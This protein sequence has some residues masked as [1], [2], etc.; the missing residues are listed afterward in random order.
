MTIDKMN[1][2]KKIKVGYQERKDT[3]TGKLAYVV[4]IDEK[5][6]LRKAASWESWRDKKLDAHEFDNVPTSGFVL[7]KKVGDYRGS[8]N[9]RQAWIRIY[10]PRGFE[11][12]IS[13]ENLL[14]IL[15]ESSCIKG[16]GLEGEFVYSWD[17]SDL[18]LLPVT[19]Q[20]Y[21]VSVEFTSMKTMKI[22]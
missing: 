22:G 5:G 14:F 16:K 15:Q 13:V 21:D 18:V 8:W 12:E 2:P 1:I 3:Y 11:F 17:K 4:Y 7:N 20:E 9:G 10:D 6:V 19:S